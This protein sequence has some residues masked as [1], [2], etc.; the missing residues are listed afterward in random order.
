MRARQM[1]V[2]V[3]EFI[4]GITVA[5][6]AALPAASGN[7]GKLALV[8]ASSGTWLVNYKSQ[9]IYYSDGSTWTY[10]GDYE[11]NDQAS[12]IQNTPAG[13]I[14]ATTVQ[15]AINELD[16]E[17]ITNPMTTGGDVIYGG[18]SG[19]PTRLANG[20]AGQVLQ[21]NGTTLAPTWTAAGAGDM[22]IASVQTVTGAKTFGGAGAVGKLIIAGST[23]GTTILDATAVAGAGTVTLPTTGTLATLAGTETLTNKSIS[24]GQITSAVAN[25]TLAATVTTNANLTGDVTSAG[26]ATTL[27]NAP[28]I[29]KVLT[30]YVS[31]AGTVAATD[32]ILAAIQKLNGND[33]TNANLTGDVT[34]TGNATTIANDAVTYA[35]M[36]NVS[37]TDKLL[38]RSTAGAGD[39]EEIT[40]TA[41]GR[42]LIDDTT[43]AA[44]A[45]TL[46]LG[47]GDS[48]QF[49]AV[50]IGHATNTTIT[51]VS[52]GV[53]AVEGN[54]VAML[55][56]TQTFSAAQVGTYTTLTDGATISINL[57]ANNFFKVLLGGNRTLAVPTGIV[58]GQNFI[59]TAYQ[60]GTGSRTVAFAWVYQ[61]PG[62]SAPTL[63][64]GKY[65]KDTLAGNVDVYST[66]TI[67]VTIA[68]PGVVTWTAHGL[69][70]GQKIQLTTTG[71][72]PTGLVASTSYWIIPVDAN[73]FQLATSLAN[74]QAGT[75]IATSGTQSGT[76]TMV[77]ATITLST[78]AAIA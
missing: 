22:I 8:L 14:S 53:I 43:A 50:N 40:C 15:A 18:A 69:Y 62:G 76:H 7:A 41:A 3:R 61:F 75:A 10:K 6:F 48:P 63:T 58:Q 9:G 44:Q 11:A 23:S 46:G 19:T 17:K 12:E 16:T 52:A 70:G 68:T 30:G 77:A 13:N 45:T 78:L 39:T 26:N 1:D 49:T 59:I 5:N 66:S 35:K 4:Y 36:Q 20:T 2:G 37:A 72:L 21:S 54:T 34:S 67:T 47:T 24:G 27:T 65:T 25:A 74:A 28:V 57:A 33:A 29:A 73:S 71:A 51:Q 32:S 60:D 42:A 64:T 55:A 38:G 56:A 31:G